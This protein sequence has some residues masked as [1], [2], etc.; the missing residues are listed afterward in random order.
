[1]LDTSRV[2]ARFAIEAVCKAAELARRINAS[3]TLMRITKKD[4]SPVTVADFAAQTVVARLLSE[5]LP[6]DALVA[7]ES[8]DSLRVPG[9]VETV[10]TVTSFV[11]TVLNGATS[12]DVCA[13]IDRGGADPGERFWALDP[14]DG[15]KG[16]L[17]GGQ[18]AVALALVERG[19][20]RLG[21]LGCPN[22]DEECQPGLQGPG[23]LVV[24]VRGEGAWYRSMMEDGDFRSLRVSAVSNPAEARVFRSHEAGHTNVDQIQELTRALGVRADPV[25]MDSQA[26]YA[27]MAAGGGELLFRLL[28][29]E[30]PGYRE[31]IWDQAAGSIIIEEAGGRI[32]D[33]DGKPLDFTQGRELQ[34]N[35]GI[36]ASN[37]VLHD[38]ALEAVARVIKRGR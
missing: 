19:V 34:C 29:P 13:W 1:V 14:L 31:R 12:G 38:Q 33:L 30:A 4:L 36:V 11:A 26:K 5:T 8:S 22:L 2:E 3:A 6:D 24:A 32:T 28:S 27:V 15:T 37:G 20:V 18:Y 16:Y 17:R 25:L 35:R 21:V 23:A 9:A 10:D 7:E